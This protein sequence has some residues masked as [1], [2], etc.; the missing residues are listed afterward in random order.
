MSA[1]AHAT[2]LK[3]RIAKPAVGAEAEAVL[4]LEGELYQARIRMW[5]QH[6][7][8][9]A[10][11]EQIK[12]HPR[13]ILVADYVG[14]ER[15]DCFREAGVPFIDTVGNAFLRTPHYYVF[16]KGNPRP[17]PVPGFGKPLQLPC[18]SN[19]GAR[20]TFAL[21]CDPELTERSD[22][23]IAHIAGVSVGTVGNVME[24]LAETDHLEDR[25][26]RRVLIRREDLLDGW[27]E[28]Y[29]V[30]LRPTLSLGLYQAEDPDW[31]KS[32]DVDRYGGYWGGEIAGAFYTGRDDATEA[33]LYVPKALQVQL[34]A[35]AHLR[36]LPRPAGG[37]GTVTMLAPF[38][39]R[40]VG[41]HGFVHPVLAY[42]DLL[43]SEK[44]RNILLSR[45]LYRQ[46]LLPRLDDLTEH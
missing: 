36:K 1:L 33:T 12:R 37:H 25:Q 43:A 13:G 16:I 8:L 38:W 22:S 21:L 39:R 27:V 23:D 46:H 19:N 32:F 34:L 44:P 7:P 2:D 11:I 45:S 15:A 42:A 9:T 14:P 35:A 41:P 5:A 17:R 24:S 20:V 29:P 26:G 6:S 18:F 28:N 4:E 3:F 10:L 30:T 40:H 31:W